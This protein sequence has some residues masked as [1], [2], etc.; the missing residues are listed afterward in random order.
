MGR[1]KERWEGEG[2][3]EGGKGVW[4]SVH[5]F[6]Y[7]MYLHTTGAAP[8]LRASPSPFSYPPSLPPSPF[9]FA[10]AL[11]GHGR[12]SG[13]HFGNGPPCLHAEGREV[14]REGR[15]GRKWRRHRKGSSSFSLA[16]HLSFPSVV[17]VATS[18][19]C[20]RGLSC[21]K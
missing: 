2:G 15:A 16:C 17:P 19:Q 4:N 7:F 8:C 3:A 20:R 14:G 10:L 9:S 1:G 11:F 21:D 6:W 12:G 18:G 5:E 13:G